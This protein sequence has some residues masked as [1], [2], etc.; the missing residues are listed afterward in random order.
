MANKNILVSNN[1]KYEPISAS[2]DNDISTLS[3]SLPVTLNTASFTG[4]SSLMQIYNG[5]LIPVPSTST[6]SSGPY[7]GSVLTYNSSEGFAPSR[8]SIASFG[9]DISGDT[10]SGVRVRSVSNVTGGVLPATYG[11]T[12]TGSFEQNSLTT[13]NGSGPTP[14][15]ANKIVAATANNYII[16]DTALLNFSVLNEPIVYLY[17]GVV[18]SNTVYTWTKPA[19]CRFI[20]VIC[21]AGGGGGVSGRLGTTTTDSVGGAGGGG[22]GIS[23]VFFYAINIPSTVQITAGR[24]GAGGIAAASGPNVPGGYGGNSLFGDF[25]FANGGTSVNSTSAVGSPG[26]VGYSLAGGYGGGGYRYNLGIYPGQSITSR[27]GAPGGGG[28]TGGYPSSNAAGGAGGAP[29]NG[30]GATSII[31][32][33]ANSALQYDF[34]NIKDYFLNNIPYSGVSFPKISSSGG[35]GAANGYTGSPRRAFNGGN[36]AY[37]SGGGGGGNG[38]TFS[39]IPGNGGNGGPGYVLIICY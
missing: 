1:G 26:G 22:G 3:S 27:L 16:G 21:Q 39:H 11:G 9:G 23:E 7:S 18:G 25:I 13:T 5:K 32:A 34:L 31:G 36:G 24:G 37:G 20:R 4:N 8:T 28:G 30:V 6:I 10:I 12:G 14:S 29:F 35:A 19:G 38:A 33:N 2:V 15:V 17:T